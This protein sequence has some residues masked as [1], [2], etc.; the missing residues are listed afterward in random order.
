[1]R[2]NQSY[3]AYYL[4]KSHGVETVKSRYLFAKCAFDLRRLEEAETCLRDGKT[5]DRVSLHP[6]FTNTDSFAFA[7]ALL[8][9]ILF[10]TGRT[11]N[12]KTHWKLALTAN[13]FLW[14]SIKNYCE[15][16]GESIK[17]LFSNLVNEISDTKMR[18]EKKNERL[19]KSSRIHE[20]IVDTSS[21]TT[22]PNN[23]QQ[24][25]V[26]PSAPK[27]KNP[28]SGNKKKSIPSPTSISCVSRR[29]NDIIETRRSTRLF[30]AQENENKDVSS[31]FPHY[32]N[33]TSAP[34]NV[35][36]MKEL[37]SANRLNSARSSERLSPVSSTIIPIDKKILYE[38]SPDENKV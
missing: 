28:A 17:Q 30:S 22:P 11:T 16:G 31:R 18:P 25:I 5:V 26:M 6:C 23:L 8:A 14:T 4:L 3:A 29:R 13:P 37:R 10:E 20:L 38:N 15:M 2:N 35:S 27:K 34:R 19:L 36:G 21:K 1:M 7:Q 33:R 24:T 12:A 9:K 32:S